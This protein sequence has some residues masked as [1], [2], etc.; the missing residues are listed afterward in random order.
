[1]AEIKITIPDNIKH[2]VFDGVAYQHSYQDRISSSDHQIIPNP[3]S[4]EQFVK[5][6]LMKF[7]KNSVKAYE[8]NKEAEKVRRVVIN[9]V[10]NDINLS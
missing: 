3:E 9:K 8:A 6:I 7:I 10:D 2:R 5:N 1:M 4:K